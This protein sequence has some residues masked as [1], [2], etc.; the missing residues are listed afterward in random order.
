MYANEDHKTRAECCIEV[1][2]VIISVIPIITV[3]LNARNFINKKKTS[4]PHHTS[5][6]CYTIMVLYGAVYA[7]II[8]TIAI[9]VV[10]LV[11]A[12]KG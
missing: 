8:T 9:N 3:L 12:R 10:M 1:I 6:Q 2:E 11:N 4:N 5:Q 7:L